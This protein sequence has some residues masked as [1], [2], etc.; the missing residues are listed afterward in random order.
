MATVTYKSFRLYSYLFL[1][2]IMYLLFALI[3]P[4]DNFFKPYSKYQAADYLIDFLYLLYFTSITVESGF[5]V[6]KLLNKYMPWEVSPRY[7]FTLQLVIQVSFLALVFYSSSKLLD[8]LT[9]TTPQP[10]DDL[11]LRQAIVIGAMVSL[12]STAVF[13]AEY[14]FNQL[15]ESRIEALQ[16]KQNAI[17]A[18]LDALKSQIDPHFLFNNFSTLSALIEEE[19]ELAM[20]FLDRLSQVYRYLLANRSQNVIPLEDELSFI[21]AYY[22]LYQ[23]RYGD[24][25]HLHIDVPF[26]KYK[27][28]IAPITLQL[29]V[30][31]AI[32]HNVISKNDP[33]NIA[34]YLEDGSVIEHNGNINEKPKL[35]IHVHVENECL[36]VENNINPK[37]FNDESLGMGLKNIAERYRLL[38]NTNPVIE[39]TSNIFRV[40]IPLLK[41]NDQ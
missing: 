2:I 41:Y 19:K 21:A 1:G 12:L 34:I 17:Q 40:K 30:E 22:F 4:F 26:E 13:T 6:T 35:N 18:Q 15:N 36:V 31:N 23:I 10:M 9:L 39:Q 20:K 7:R 38:S 11:L 14:F 32:K 37:E 25:I 27:Y 29:L 28:G 24:C 16:L 3:N 5:I 8:S 33:L